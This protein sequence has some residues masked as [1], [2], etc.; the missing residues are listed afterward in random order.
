MHVARTLSFE[1]K[2]ALLG[3]L[4]ASKRMQFEQVTEHSEQADRA[5]SWPLQLNFCHFAFDDL[6]LLFNAARQAQ[7][8]T[9]VCARERGRASPDANGLAERLRERLR[10]AHFQRVH[11][12]A[13]DGSERCVNSTAHRKDND[14]TVS[15]RESKERT[16]I[17]FAIAMAI[18]VFPVPGWP[19]NRMPRPAILPYKM[20]PVHFKRLRA[21][22]HGFD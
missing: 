8:Q 4:Q 1:P 5:T 12:R 16:C 14:S 15:A 11:F 3:T 9:S 19:A 21:C 22:P 10:F 20:Q 7:E 18:A 6:C 17:D 13:R 2:F